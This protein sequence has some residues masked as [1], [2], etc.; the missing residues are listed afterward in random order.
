M[1]HYN[2]DLGG[3]LYTTFADHNGKIF[4][5]QCALAKYF[6]KM[7]IS[8]TVVDRLGARYYFYIYIYI[9]NE[10]ILYLLLY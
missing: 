10:V 2:I 8:H 1:R 3:E 6:A 4:T 9:S 5:F 7:V